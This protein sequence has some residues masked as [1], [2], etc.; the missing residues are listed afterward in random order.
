MTEQATNPINEC[1][2][3]YVQSECSPNLRPAKLLRTLL[4]FWALEKDYELK[5][6]LLNSMAVKHALLMK[7]LVDL[8]HLKNKFL[9]IAA[10][11]LRNPLISIRGLSEIILSEATGP[12]TPEQRE[13]LCIVHSVSDGML[14]LVNNLLDV[15]VI[16]SGGLELQRGWGSLKD[17]IEERIRIHKVLAAEKG[18]MLHATLSELDRAH[19]FDAGKIAQVIDNLL[20]NA[21]KFSP[22]HANVFIGLVKTDEEVTVSIR[23]EGPGIPEEDQSRIFGEFQVSTS[24]PTG[25]E[26]STGLGL[27]IAK[28]I[29]E[30]H[31]GVMGVRSRPGHGAQFHFTLPAG[32]DNDWNST[33]QSAD[34]RR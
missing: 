26:K 10:H 6:D 33:P 30:A 14:N 24:L 25:G 29:V 8:N 34:R 16:E 27:A 17:L 32:C 1:I 4:E 11:D 15:S 13:Y 5:S 22:H 19:F 7:N 18:I 23:D 9:G 21:I 31:K 3:D 20:S 2:T 12:L 28:R